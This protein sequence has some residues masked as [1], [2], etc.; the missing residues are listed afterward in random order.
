MKLR[1]TLETFARRQNIN[2]WL[3]AFNNLNK[4]LQLIKQN[5]WPYGGISLLVI[6][7]FLQLPALRQ[8]D[9]FAERREG[10][11]EALYLSL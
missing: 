1:N 10:A 6:G 2:Y 9:I 4:A 8:Q 5:A 7:N 11:Y 3:D